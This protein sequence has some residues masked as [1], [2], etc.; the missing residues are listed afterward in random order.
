MALA[1]SRGWGYLQPEQLQG[2]PAKTPEGWGA[3]HMGIPGRVDAMLNW[4]EQCVQERQPSPTE[5]S[6][7]LISITMLANM[8][9]FK[10]EL[11]F[12]YTITLKCCFVWYHLFV[13][14]YLLLYVKQCSPIA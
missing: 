9:A 3:A 4:T 7:I 1:D 2:R 8:H 14:Y 5:F 10:T 6:A 13:I 12:F 11:I